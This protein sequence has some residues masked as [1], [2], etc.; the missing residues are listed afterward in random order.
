MSNYLPST[1]CF[2]IKNG[3]LCNILLQER[4]ITAKNSALVDITTVSWCLLRVHLIIILVRKLHRFNACN[5]WLLIGQ[6]YTWDNYKRHSLTRSED[7]VMRKDFLSI[8]RFLVATI[9]ANIA[10]NIYRCYNIVKIPNIFCRWYTTA[11]VRNSL[12]KAFMK[13]YC[14]LVKVNACNVVKYQS[15][16]S[17]YRENDKLNYHCKKNNQEWL[18]FLVL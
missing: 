15:N 6:I 18:S 4:L 3:L 9:I 12:I 7:S 13:F 2:K 11:D 10:K 14:C 16:T 8:L 5:L 17:S 1:S